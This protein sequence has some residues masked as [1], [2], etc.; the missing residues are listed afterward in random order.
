MEARRPTTFFFESSLREVNSLSLEVRLFRGASS[1]SV[2]N[3]LWAQKVGK[4]GML[5]SLV[6]R[7]G[8]PKMWQRLGGKRSVN[9]LLLGCLQLARPKS[10]VVKLGKRGRSWH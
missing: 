8:I 10:R 7:G 4:F 5:I 9:L 3:I 2:S 6:W 1:V